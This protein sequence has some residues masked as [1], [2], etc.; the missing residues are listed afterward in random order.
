MAPRPKKK[1]KGKTCALVESPLAYEPAFERSEVLN[2]EGLDKVR[3]ALA[4]DS[5]EWKATVAWP[6]SRAMM[7]MAATEIP[8]H[9]HALWAGL[10]P[11]FSDFFNAVL[12]HYQ[13]HALHLDP[14]S[15]ILLAVFAFVCEAMVGIAPSVALFRH[16]FSLHLVDA[17]QCSGCVAFQAVAATAGSGID[18]E[19]SPAVNGFR[20]RWVFVDAGVLNSL[21]LLP[22]APAVPSSGW[23][24]VK[25]V[26]HR[27]AHVWRR[28]ARLKKLGVTAPMVVKEF[29]QC[30]IAPLQR[31]SRPMWTFSGSRDPMRLHVPVLPPE[32]LRTVLEFLY[33]CSNKVE[34]MR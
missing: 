9:L 15:I 23:G 29:I 33:C 11:P 28:L 4:A 24:H 13:V 30:R 19:L 34:F 14:Q 22:R 6:A 7:D 21:L 31:H 3:P 20:K 5:N 2:Q 18:F 1:G 17:R 8:I 25:L 12:S 10:I 26:D 27:L 16:F 32:A